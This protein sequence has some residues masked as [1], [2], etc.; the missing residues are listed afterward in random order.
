MTRTVEVY[1]LWPDNTWDKQ[2]IVVPVFDGMN[3]DALEAR[4]CH[5]AWLEVTRAGGRKPVQIGM[6]MESIYGQVAE[7]Y[8]Q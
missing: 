2:K 8:T 6:L 3:D 5:I 7:R 1:R 4:A